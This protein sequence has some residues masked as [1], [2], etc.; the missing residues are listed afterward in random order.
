MVSC[1]ALEVSEYR[2]ECLGARSSTTYREYIC[3]AAAVLSTEEA[4]NGQAI[5]IAKVRLRQTWSEQA[6]PRGNPTTTK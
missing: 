6:I 5:G 2:R 1:H 4:S 3:H